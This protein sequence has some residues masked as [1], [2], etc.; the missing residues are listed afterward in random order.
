MEL[1]AT[2]HDTTR[3]RKNNICAWN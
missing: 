3:H 1:Q 2:S